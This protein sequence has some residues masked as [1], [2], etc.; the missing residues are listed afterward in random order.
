MNNLLAYSGQ[1]ILS[2]ITIS[3]LVFGAFY[4]NPKKSVAKK[5]AKVIHISFSCEVSIKNGDDIVFT[6]QSPN[7][8]FKK[9]TDR[10]Q[11]NL[12]GFAYAIEDNYS[13]LT[14]CM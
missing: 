6:S 11:S 4:F 8:K 5:N 13:R 7:T 10:H 14:A 2:V 12:K 3:S 1:I 9:A